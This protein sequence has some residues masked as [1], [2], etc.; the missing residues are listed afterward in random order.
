MHLRSLLEPQDALFSDEDFL[1]M[2][3]QEQREF[4][5]E[6]TDT[7]QDGGWGTPVELRSDVCR[8]VTSVDMLRSQ[9]ACT[10]HMNA[11]DPDAS[12]ALN[13][14]ELA[15]AIGCGDKLKEEWSEDGLQK[16]SWYTDDR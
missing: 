5:T 12:E 9:S 2:F 16:E 14:A 8:T 13:Q 4:S 1:K 15:S 3:K 7:K 6:N 10:A 11:N